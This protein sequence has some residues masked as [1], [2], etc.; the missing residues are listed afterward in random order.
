M[1][2]NA[3][4]ASVQDTLRLEKP[5][6]PSLRRVRCL[7]KWRSFPFLSDANNDWFLLCLSRLN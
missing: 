5:D 3:G 2:H 7:Q 6:L 1:F 4:L